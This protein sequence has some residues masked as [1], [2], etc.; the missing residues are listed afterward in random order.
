VTNSNLFPRAPTEREQATRYL[1][2]NS[3]R[4]RCPPPSAS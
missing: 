3:P 4:R 2:L 1:D